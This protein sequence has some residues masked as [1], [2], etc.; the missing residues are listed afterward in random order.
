MQK[1]NLFTSA[2][3]KSREK[4]L[5]GTEKLLRLLDSPTYDDG[6]RLLT[7]FGFGRTAKVQ[8]SLPDMLYAEEQSLIEFI[9]EYAPAT[10][11]ANY[12]LLGYDFLNAEALL[13]AQA[14]NMDSQKYLTHTG[15]LTLDE[16]KVALAGGECRIPEI[17]DAFLAGQ[18]LF[19]QGTPTG[20]HLDTVFVRGLYSALLRLVKNKALKKVIVTEIDLKN[21]SILLR[22][23]ER[24]EYEKLKL[25]GGTLT[26]KQEDAVLSGEESRI[27]NAFK[28]GALYEFVVAA[29]LAKDQPLAEF[30]RMTESFALARFKAERFSLT[31]DGPFILYCMYRRADVK[32]VRLIMISLFNG[33][34]KTKIRA[35]IRESY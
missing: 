2:V 31:K 1:N 24:D 19:D 7:D 6:L 27:K 14:L 23:K 9:N 32:N 22:A 17:K 33:A 15:V 35:K 5:L 26:V 29:L 30:E 18:K 10:G 12:F 3:C 16:L 34:D 11:S 25:F 28:S 20:A 4:Y 13:K 8:S 21:F